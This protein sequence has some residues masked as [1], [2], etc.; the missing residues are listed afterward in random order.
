MICIRNTARIFSR[1]PTTQ[2]R[3][4]GNRG[5]KIAI[6]SVKPGTVIDLKGKPHLVLKATHQTSGRGSAHVKLDLK[7]V[8]NGGK[9]TEK[10]RTSD[11]VEGVHVSTRPFQYLYHDDTQIHVMHPET[12]EQL[13]IDVSTLQGGEKVVS[14]LSDTIPVSISFWKDTAILAKLPSQ[15][16]LPIVET[17]APQKAATNPSAKGIGY[18]TAVLQGNIKVEV[19][20]FCK[21]G[22]EIEISLENGSATY[23][24]RVK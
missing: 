24:R 12:F 15:L 19:P 21:M 8:I 7:D 18:K 14:M 22:D 2:F 13:S 10:Y 9:I 3:I 23:L 20:E 5:I 16:K 6:N 1:V 17:N 4:I 11:S